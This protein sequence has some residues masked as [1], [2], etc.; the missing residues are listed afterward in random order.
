MGSWRRSPAQL[1]D[2]Q[3]VIAEQ[4]RRLPMWDFYGSKASAVPHRRPHAVKPG[5]LV[6]PAR[7]REWRARKLLSIEPIGAA[8]RRV[9]A[10]RK[11][12]GQG[13]GLEII[14]ESRHVA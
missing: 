2:R 1:A 7:R 5:T 11:H 4:R 12:A 6:G 10:M 14:A 9:L 8:L 3:M 13:F